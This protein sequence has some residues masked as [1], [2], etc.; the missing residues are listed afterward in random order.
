MRICFLADSLLTVLKTNHKEYLISEN[1]NR[2]EAY[3]STLLIY[4]EIKL[5]NYLYP[6]LA[7][8]PILR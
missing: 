2:S 8:P 6:V 5:H 3:E 7:H 1:S 4:T